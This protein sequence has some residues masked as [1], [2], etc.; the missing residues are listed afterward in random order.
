MTQWSPFLQG[1]VGE[2]TRVRDVL[3]EAGI[4]VELWRTA[5]DAKG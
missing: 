2:L 3:A 1:G 5:A 4:P